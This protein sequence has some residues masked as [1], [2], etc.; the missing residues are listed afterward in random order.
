MTT[1]ESRFF[2]ENFS[3]ALAGGRIHAYFQPIYRSLT[4]RMIC[5][6][7]L[8]RW[9]DPDKGVISPALFIPVLEKNDLIFSLDMEIL[10][11]ACELYDELRSRG[12]L[13]NGFSVNLS[14]QDFKHSELYD[15]VVE[16]L[17]KYDV[18]HS[19]IKLEITESLMLEDPE[20]FKDTLQKFTDSGFSMWMD[21]FGSGYSSLNVLKNYKFDLMKFDML[22][23]QDFSATGRKLLASLINMAK[24]LGIHTLTEGV[25]LKE[26]QQFLQAAGCESLQGFYF[27]KPVSREEL[28]EL[29]DKEYSSLESSNDATYWQQIGQLNFLSARPLEEYSGMDLYES[30][31]NPEFDSIGIPLALLECHHNTCK[32]IYSS[33]SYQSRI[34]QLGY[35][36]IEELENEFNNRKNEQYTILKKAIDDAI[37]YG[38]IRRLEY[39]KNDVYFRLSI[40]CLAQEP[41]RAMLALYLS[42]FD[43]EREVETAKEM[44]SYG[45][46]LFS[47][48]ELVVLFYPDKSMANRIYTT[49]NLPAY[50]REASLDMSVKKFCEKEVCPVDQE[51]YLR[52]LNFSTVFD[53]VDNS[54]EGFVQGFFR[55]RWGGDQKVWHIAR[56]SKVVSP[57]E[58]VFILTIQRMHGKGIE[59]L[60]L[61]SKEHPE[62]LE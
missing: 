42:T 8:A 43:S 26:Q 56:L 34:M 38:T 2:A 5:A 59:V 57:S 15:T 3:E 17:D 13:I 51:R 6:E 16:T 33:K 10:R 35:S 14:R 12:T 52:F 20:V 9:I 53:K 18:P 21:D 19:A 25:E 54:P 7:S 60:D 48:Y 47:T 36:S 29:I 40:K 45:N 55:M 39:M 24:S 46:S 23:L 41:D 49:N 50:D 31:I 22:F 11:Q 1:D 32:Y 30:I 58:R 62:L 37:N 44:L 4:G 61:I 27:S 28:I